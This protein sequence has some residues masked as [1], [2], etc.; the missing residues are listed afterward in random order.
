MFTCSY[1]KRE[2]KLHK[3]A[4]VEHLSGFFQQ[5]LHYLETMS[6]HNKDGV[7]GKEMAEDD[8]QVP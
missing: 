6:E 4:K 8:L 7:F 1:V 2:F 5:W 3:S